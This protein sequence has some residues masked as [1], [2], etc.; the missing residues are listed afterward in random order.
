M[1][2]TPSI[3]F[4]VLSL[5]ASPTNPKLLAV[6]GRSEVVVLVL[7]RKEWSA[8]VS[9]RI[10]CRTASIGQYHHGPR[11][12]NVASVKWHPLGF[13]GATLC[14]LT[15]D[16]VLREYDVNGDVSEPTSVLDFAQSNLSK[17]TYARPTRHSF[18]SP[19]HNASM[20][21]FTEDEDDMEAVSLCFGAGSGD[22]G[23]LTA[24]CLMRDGTIFAVCPYLPQTA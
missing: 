15:E 21:S 12:S 17:P 2:N 19:S 3:T 24:Y 1:L 10:D 22:W 5:I 7:P 11:S 20:H 6:V 8:L 4:D 13:R 23:P 18:A 16:G 14:I 9:G